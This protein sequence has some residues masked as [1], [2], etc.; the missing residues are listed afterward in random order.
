MGVVSDIKLYRRKASDGVSLKITETDDGGENA[1][2]SKV[3][4]ASPAH[5][6]KYLEP[7]VSDLQGSQNSP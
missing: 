2:D 7:I 5:A 3:N 4:F 1:R 6:L